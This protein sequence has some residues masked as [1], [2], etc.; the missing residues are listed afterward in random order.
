MMS[1]LADDTVPMRLLRMATLLGK[2]GAGP[3]GLIRIEP[4]LEDLQPSG[5]RTPITA[6]PLS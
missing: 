4:E 1:M 6:Y 5:G 2:D 3:N